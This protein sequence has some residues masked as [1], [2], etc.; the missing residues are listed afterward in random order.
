MTTEDSD[1]WTYE[2]DEKKARLNEEKHGV[3][4]QEGK[5]V[6]NDA[7]SITIPDPDHSDDEERWID[8]GLSVSGNLLVVCYTERGNSTRII[9]CRK[10]SK[11]E[12][13]KYEHER[14]PKGY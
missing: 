7:F 11:S 8:L 5:T 6:F 2:W 13:E 1:E 3:S 10:A 4:F 12:R 9:G 14:T